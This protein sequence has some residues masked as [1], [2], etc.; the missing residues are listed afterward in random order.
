M[1]LTVIDI[2]KIKKARTGDEV[3]IIGKQGRETISADEVADKIGTIN[4]EVA[5][6]LRETLPRYYL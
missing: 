5:T 1:D 6:R 4:Y 3:V 2:S